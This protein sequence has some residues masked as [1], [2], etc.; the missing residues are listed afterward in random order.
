M[1]MTRKHFLP[2]GFFVGRFAALLLVGAVAAVG[3]SSGGEA[4]AAPK[5]VARKTASAPPSVDSVQLPPGISRYEGSSIRN[6]RQAN[7]ARSLVQGYD[8]ASGNHP[9]VGK[10]QKVQRTI[11]VPDDVRGK[12]KAVKL[13]IKNKADEE[14]NQ[15]KTVSL[16]SS[17]TLAD[18]GI[19]VTVGP[20]LPNFAMTDTSYTSMGNRPENPAVQLVV[21]E[22]GRRIYEGWA[23]SK[24]PGLYAFPHER[25]G[26]QLM[27]FIPEPV[28]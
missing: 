22:N 16:G 20:F 2:P 26:I 21:E 12:W 25:F 1:L 23:F 8:D 5:A 6:Q 28:S 27:D 11:A 18:S 14:R 7:A 4:P 9:N 19:K 13:M 3:C 24:F 10:A 17:F 15:M